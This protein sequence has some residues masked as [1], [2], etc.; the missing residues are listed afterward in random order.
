MNDIQHAHI[1]VLG[2]LTT[3]TTP[4][5]TAALNEMNVGGEAPPINNLLVQDLSQRTE[6]G[7]QP[8]VGVRSVSLVVCVC[9]DTGGHVLFN[10]T[11]DFFFQRG[12]NLDRHECV[13]VCEGG[14]E[15]SGG[16]NKKKSMPCIGL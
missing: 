9:L 8:L 3:R 14:G 1:S 2:V 16:C 15:G 5:V 12:K 7:G 4:F 10:V 11:H 6:E 13:W